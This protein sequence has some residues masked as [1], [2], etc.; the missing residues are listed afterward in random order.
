MLSSFIEKFASLF[1]GNIEHFAQSILGLTKSAKLSGTGKPTASP[2][3]PISQP[4][5]TPS[6]PSSG[7]SSGSSHHG[8]N[9]HDHT[10]HHTDYYRNYYDRPWWNFFDDYVDSYYYGFPPYRPV[11]EQPT[12]VIKNDS[13]DQKQNVKYS[14]QIDYQLYLI[15]A[16]VIIVI[17]MILK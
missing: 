3:P 5:I 1:G 2:S 14:Q 4:P 9:Y 13:S 12:I 8:S 16:L 7:S 17:I 11:V 6:K 10:D 15:Y